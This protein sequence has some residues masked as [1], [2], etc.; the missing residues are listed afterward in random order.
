MILNQIRNVGIQF[1]CLAFL[2]NICFSQ[3]LKFQTLGS[4][5]GLTDP[6]IYTINQDAKGFLWIGTSNGIFRYDGYS[7]RHQHTPDSPGGNF[8]NTSYKDSGNRL[9]FGH[10]NGSL[11]LFSGKDYFTYQTDTI[12]PSAV[13]GICEDEQGMIWISLQ[14][15][16]VYLMEPGSELKKTVNSIGNVLIFSMVPL[17]INRFLFGTSEGL[18]LADY[19]QDQNRLEFPEKTIALEGIMINF[20]LK[21]RNGDLMAVSSR[22]GVFTLDLGEDGNVNAR[23]VETMK[24]LPLLNIKGA[25]LDSKGNLWLGTLGQGVIRINRVSENSQFTEPEQINTGSGMPSDDVQCIFEDS[26]GNMW[27]GLYGMGLARMIRSNLSFYSYQDQLASNSFYSLA[28]DG[29]QLWAGSEGMLVRLSV[30]DGS[31]KQVYS[32]R[33]GIPADQITALYLQPGGR[34]WMGTRS[35]GLHVMDLASG[36]VHRE[37]ISRDD[38]SNSVN[39]IT[40]RGNEIWIATKNGLCQV[41]PGEKKNWINT[42]NG[43]S[44]NNIQHLFI[45]SMGLVLIATRSNRLQFIDEQGNLNDLKIPNLTFPLPVTC[46]SEDK[47]GN[48][49]LGTYGNGV[50]KIEHSASRHYLV[51]SGLHSDYCYALIS[52]DP[53]NLLVAHRGG[54]SKIDLSSDMVISLEEDAG[55]NGSTEF[56]P[57]AVISD[58]KDQIWFGTSEGLIAYDFVNRE[59]VQHPPYLNL[60]GVWINNEPFDYQDNIELKPGFYKIE[61]EYTG[62]S[63]SNPES[64]R[65]RHYLEGFDPEWSDFTS[66][67]RLTYGRIGHGVYVFQLEAINKENVPSKTPVNLAI[68]IKSP[69]YLK[70]WFYLLLIISVIGS[71][72]FII[73]IRERNLKRI[74]IR[75]IRNLD[76]KTKEVIL[77]EEIIRERKKVEKE[78][79][80]ARNRAEQSDQLKSAFLANISHEI[81]TPMNAIV[82]FSHLLGNR[83]IPEEKREKFIDLIQSN[84]DYLLELM[85]NIIE[86]SNLETG[87]MQLDLRVCRL[88]PFLEKVYNKN[89][90]R[91]ERANK[92]KSIE[93]RFVRGAEDDNF[94]FL[95]DRLRLGQIMERLLDNAIK[96]TEQGHIYFGY[97]LND[98][99]IRFFVE[100]TG[101]GMDEE[102]KEYI[103]KLFGKSVQEDKSK[104]YSGTGLGLS[105]SQRLVALLKGELG[106]ESEPGKGST[107]YF[108]LPLQSKKAD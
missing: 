91:L 95:T 51:E 10:M 42:E 9:W 88:N 100:D 61:L 33:N 36:E 40:G 71:V 79:I 105:I 75:L 16:D 73:R 77:K 89:V 13:S 96:F 11:G 82:G 38:L 106:V 44:H 52:I 62:I 101:I 39:Y 63:F 3:Q 64:V 84:S 5:A 70:T 53:D 54:I 93:F 24:D 4:E 18:Y 7:F 90:I 58:G 49:W 81:R 2:G 57:N 28:R 78:L 66:S 41:V 102:K 31:I 47:H 26:E 14:N 25:L 65:Y 17:G 6:F 27:F 69:F 8:I 87:Q 34:L 85:D 30:T 45:D 104:L 1:C 94:E 68:K 50:Y 48:I 21:G 103:F 86:L 92:A 99:Y 67:R 72:Y 12:N 19:L 56:N 43:L 15:G 83:D 32:I 80:E 107:F 20:L 35:I 46:I 37:F 55:I 22:Q 108:N 59:K 23:L 29:D 76:D 97:K 60:T 98:R 74:Q